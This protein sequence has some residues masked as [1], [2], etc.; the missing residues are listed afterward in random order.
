MRRDH[1]PGPGQGH[2]WTQ[3]RTGGTGRHGNGSEYA[4]SRRSRPACRRPHHLTT[5]GCRCPADTY[6]RSGEPASGGSRRRPPVS[7]S[8]FGR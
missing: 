7:Q 5:A 4:A 2:R 8:G 3:Q 1:R 6:A